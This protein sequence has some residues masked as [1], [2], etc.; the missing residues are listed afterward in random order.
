MSNNS[1]N[2]IDERLLF[3]NHENKVSS[4]IQEE[5]ASERREQ[6]QNVVNNDIREQI[7]AVNKNKSIQEGRKASER[8]I[9][10]KKV[11]LEK[12]LGAN[13]LKKKS[14][15]VLMNK[16]WILTA[17]FMGFVPGFIGLHVVAAGSCFSNKVKLRLGDK[18]GIALLDLLLALFFMAIITIIIIVVYM[19]AHSADVIIEA[20]KETAIET[21]VDM[22]KSGGPLP[23]IGKKIFGWIFN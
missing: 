19:F 16:L 6:E 22:A 8:I 2:S 3:F 20:T 18:I 9:K 17:S 4:Q 14:T 5:R 15:G 10:S 12:S 13:K 21:T 7:T 11:L 1:F 23:W